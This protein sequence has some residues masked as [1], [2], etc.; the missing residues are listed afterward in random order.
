MVEKSIMERTESPDEPFNNEEEKEQQLKS[1]PY[2][3]HV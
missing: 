1:L 2:T 3:S